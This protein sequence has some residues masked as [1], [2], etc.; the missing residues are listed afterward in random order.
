MSSAPRRRVLIIEDEPD[1]SFV[2][3]TA[4]TDEGYEVRA[5]D[6]HDR[7][8]IETEVVGHRPDCVL[9]DSA[10]SLGYEGSWQTAAELGART[11]PVPVVMLTA[12]VTDAAEAIAGTT[13][14]ARAARFRAVFRKPFELGELLDAIAEITMPR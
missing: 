6:T 13:D 11:P 4:L 10:S 8:T 2:L 14:R 12:H 5:L 1:L 7:A 9:L 3:T